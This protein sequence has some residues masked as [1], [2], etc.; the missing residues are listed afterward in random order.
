MGTHTEVFA[1]FEGGGARGMAHVAALAEAQRHGLVFTGVAGTSAGAIIAALIA[2]GYTARRLYDPVT[3]QGILAGSLSDLFSQETWTE[4][5]AFSASLQ[6]RMNHRSKGCSWMR[7]YWR[8]RKLLRGV[9]I[10]LGL[11]DTGPIEAAIDRWLRAGNVDVPHDQPRVLFRDLKSELRIIAS[12]L[13][14]RSAVVFSRGETPEISVARAVVA[15]IAIPF[16]FR[17]VAVDF[18]SGP[19][20]LVDGGLV[21]NFPAWVFNA[22]L[23][24]VSVLTRVIGFRLV[25]AAGKRRSAFTQ[26]LDDLYNTTLDANIELHARGLDDLVMI[27]MKVGVSTFDFELS[28]AAKSAV[29]RSAAL[30]VREELVANFFP[31]HP[32]VLR[33]LLQEALSL[34][35]DWSGIEARRLRAN[36]TVP[37]SRATLRIVCGINMDEDADDRLEFDLAASACGESWTSKTVV[38]FDVGRYLQNG[39]QVPGLNKYQRALVRPTLST[40]LSIPIH[41]VDHSAGDRVNL[42]KPLIG[43]LNF[44]SDS[45]TMADFEQARTAGELA[46]VLLATYL[47]SPG[48]ADGAESQ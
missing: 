38:V 1:I 29:Y 42:S 34:F 16:F 23:R 44:D 19:R 31:R 15:S 30:Q 43:I 14:S 39:S 12:D 48:P 47:K 24:R 27:P 33:K 25:A 21:A 22:E 40:I 3:Q 2:V 5:K 8:W 28:A 41:D 6:H 4:F 37:T 35:S 36:F 11:I 7:F 18:V 45:A 17:P 13:D 26:F 20:T 32:D 10:D 9:G 46:A